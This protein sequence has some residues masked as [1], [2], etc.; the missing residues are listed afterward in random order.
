MAIHPPWTGP[1]AHLHFL[2]KRIPQALYASASAHFAHVFLA[3]VR[4]SGADV[5]QA[6][7]VEGSVLHIQSVFTADSFNLMPL[8]LRSSG[9]ALEQNF[10]AHAHERLGEEERDS[11]AQKR[12]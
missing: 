11:S 7:E 10:E 12:I 6:R 1:E 2:G 3:G 5:E 9:N 4:I 8:N